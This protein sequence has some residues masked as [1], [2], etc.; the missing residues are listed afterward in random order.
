MCL[1]SDCVAMNHPDAGLYGRHTQEI[2]VPGR[3]RKGVTE[4]RGLR[5][6]MSSWLKHNVAAADVGGTKSHLRTRPEELAP[7]NYSI[8]GCRPTA[9]SG[10]CSARTPP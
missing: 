9:L 10:R 5:N 6:E 3:M 8:N 1:D 2:G 7:P 4:R